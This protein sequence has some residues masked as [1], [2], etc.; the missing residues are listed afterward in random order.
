MDIIHSLTHLLSTYYMTS[1]VL[2]TG[3]T[4]G[5]KALFYFMPH[6]VEVTGD[7]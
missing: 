1:S 6:I 5:N 7:F 4:N 2:G 3:D